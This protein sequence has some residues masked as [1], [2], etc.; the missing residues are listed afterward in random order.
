MI[1]LVQPNKPKLLMLYKPETK[2]KRRLPEKKKKSHLFLIVIALNFFRQD[3]NSSRCSLGD[4]L[5]PCP[6][7]LEGVNADLKNSS[8]LY[9][10]VVTYRGGAKL[11]VLVAAE[12]FLILLHAADSHYSRVEG[13][14]EPDR[15]LQFF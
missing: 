1:S 4:D 13:A 14:Q 15:L 9:K 6:M 12:S 2:S 3:W 10:V 8:L 7:A 5:Q 11:S